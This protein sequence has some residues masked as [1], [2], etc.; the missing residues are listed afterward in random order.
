MNSLTIPELNDL[1]SNAQVNDEES[2]KSDKMIPAAIIN[3]V[4][5]FYVVMRKELKGINPTTKENIIIPSKKVIRF[6]GDEKLLNT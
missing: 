3:G 2:L 1:I 6:V 4:G 5:T